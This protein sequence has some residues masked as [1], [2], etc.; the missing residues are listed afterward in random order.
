MCCSCDLQYCMPQTNKKN[1]PANSLNSMRE[2]GNQEL[3]RIA[4]PIWSAQSPSKRWLTWP[5]IF[6]VFHGCVFMFFPQEQVQVNCVENTLT[7]S[8]LIAQTFCKD[9]FYL[10]VLIF[11]KFSYISLSRVF[12]QQTNLARSSSP[13]FLWPAFCILR[14][15]WHSTAWLVD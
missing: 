9:T 5:S 11:F 15:I 12:A 3:H 6:V 14:T 7:H 1:D 10:C 13:I 8:S 4:S 2:K